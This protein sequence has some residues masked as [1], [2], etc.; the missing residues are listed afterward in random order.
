LV[1]ADLRIAGGTVVTVDR[2]HTAVRADVYVEGGRI[3]AVGG[4]ARRARRTLDATGMLVIPGLINLHDHLRDLTPGI[5]LGE[6]LKLDEM[7]RRFWEL[8]RAAGAAEYRVGAALGRGW[9]RHRSR[10]MRRAGS[11]GSWLAAS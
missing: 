10:A 3:A 11:G 9:P 8:G 6:G 1:V 2:Q 4:E 7:L 5:R